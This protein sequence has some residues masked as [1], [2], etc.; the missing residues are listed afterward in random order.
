MF[1]DAP[2]LQSLG[3]VSSWVRCRGASFPPGH[4]PGSLYTSASLGPEGRASVCLF[5]K[6]TH[7]PF[8]GNSRKRRRSRVHSHTS[9]LS[10]SAPLE[11]RASGCGSGISLN[12]VQLLQDVLQGS[13][14]PRGSAH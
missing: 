3:L 6:A 14:T 4:R 12:P 1:G 7:M 13:L 10:W 5:P 8:M 9:A 2:G 11:S